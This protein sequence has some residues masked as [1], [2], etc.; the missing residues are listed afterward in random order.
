M[1][2]TFI[3]LA[4]AFLYCRRAVFT[5]I[6]SFAHNFSRPWHHAGAAG[7]ITLAPRTPIAQRTIN[8]YEQNRKKKFIELLKYS[9]IYEEIFFTNQLRYFMIT[10]N[11]GYLDV[12]LKP[13]TNAIYERISNTKILIFT[14]WQ[15]ARDQMI[16]QLAKMAV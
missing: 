16:Y 2:V 9:A 13:H 7:R 12:V 8:N 5:T 14:N 1:A 3:S 15:W 4:T 6:L 10:V 11:V